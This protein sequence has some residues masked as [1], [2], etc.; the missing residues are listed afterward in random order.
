MF[1]I[2]RLQTHQ[3]LLVTAGQ[4][5][6]QQMLEWIAILACQGKVMVV[7]GGNQFNIYRVAKSIRRKTAALHGSLQNITISRSF[8]CYQMAAL[9]EQLSTAPGPLFM[10]D[11]LFSFYDEDIPLKESLRLLKN[12]L[13]RLVLLSHNVPLII[14]TRPASFSP[15]RSILLEE[16]KDIATMLWEGQE[17]TAQQSK[18]LT[19][20]PWTQE[21]SG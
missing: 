12:S 8:S 17:E 15:E 7:D 1:S 16:V 11:F 9:L 20:L 19:L 21:N 14:S 6:R 4:A 3:V 2:T 5:A 13:Q 18:P 10:L